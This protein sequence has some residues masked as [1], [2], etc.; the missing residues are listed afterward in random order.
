[1]GTCPRLHSAEYYE[2]SGKR[3]ETPLCHLTAS[4]V[5]GQA[6]RSF[7]GP[8]FRKGN[9]GSMNRCGVLASVMKTPR[10]HAALGGLMLTFCC[11]PLTS[12]LA[13]HTPPLDP[14]PP[15]PPGLIGDR[16]WL[17]LDR[18]G[19]Q[20]EGEPGMAGIVVAL[21]DCDGNTI[22]STSTTAAGSYLFSGVP[23]G[24][25]R[26][27]FVRP[28]GYAFTSPLAG[29]DPA[30]DS[31]ANAFGTTDCFVLV[32]T[33][34]VDSID[35]GLVQLCS[36]GGLAWLDRNRNGIRERREVL[37][38]GITIHLLSC[39]G[40]E[41]NQTETGDD[42]TYR[43]QD[44]E[45]GDYQIGI[46]PMSGLAL[47][48]P[49]AGLETS[50]SDVFPETGMTECLTLAFGQPHAEVDAGIRFGFGCITFKQ[51]DWGALPG[52][53]HVSDRLTN[54]FAR[55]Y[56]RGLKV[57]IGNTLTFTTAEAIE[58]FLPADGPPAVL[59]ADQ[60]DPMLTEAGEFAGQVVALKLNVDFAIRKQTG[61]NILGLRIEPGHKFARY[62]V[63][64]L[65]AL[66]QR[67][68]GGRPDLLPAG[69]SV[70]DLNDAIARVNRNFD[71]GMMDLGFL[72]R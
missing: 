12:V 58:R 11:A 29:A 43:F 52:E 26:V 69:L 8:S 17:D 22:A 66:A 40:L 53:S 4:L 15:P 38:K 37:L 32:E 35:A 71:C 33:Q 18:N 61:R 49:N 41:I 5:R 64:R 63:A 51:E 20:D 42:G 59:L 28:I 25:Y 34:A 16:V 70:A 6:Q 31:D 30:I 9:T 57:G 24:T 47:T 65:L 67:V 19:L 60:T 44:L 54:C 55:F 23:P 68:L 48:R 7:P 10:S 13:H 50:D 45:P 27:H 3:S 21:E 62:R 39:D 56:K 1:M 14:S 36:I 2:R 46:A 72:G